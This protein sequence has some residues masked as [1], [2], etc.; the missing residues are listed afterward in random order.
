[1]TTDQLQ[2]RPSSTGNVAAI[3]CGTNSTRLLIV[4]TRGRQLERMMRITR[5]GQGVDRENRLASEAIARTLDVLFEFKT[6]LDL[7]HV[8]QVRMVATSAVRDAENGDDFL[9]GAK[10]TIGVSAE[11]LTGTHEGQLAYAGAIED[12]EPFDGDTLVIDI[13][14]GST[15]LILGRD[16]VVTAVSLQLGCV[17]L[18]ERYLRGDPPDLDGEASLR[19]EI[20]REIVRAEGEL[21]NLRDLASRRRLIGLAG[22]VS[23]LSALD[24][25]LPEYDFERLHHSVL[26]LTRV[27]ELC[28][29]LRSLPISQRQRLVGMAPGREDVILGG[30]LILET[31]MS[32]YLFDEVIVS[33]RDILDGIAMTLRI[34]P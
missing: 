21:P 28:A 31:V 26:G 11:V 12:L 7:H 5:L 34:D 2:M 17:R 8:E 30:A 23:T 16:S 18:T 27:Q 22:T 4:D 33:E 1:M 25:E 13:G 14:G 15:E 24:M 20:V 3:D 29:R 32:R 9:R 19:R 10:Q 6:Q